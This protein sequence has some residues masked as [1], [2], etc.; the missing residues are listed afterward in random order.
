M[1]TISKLLL[2]SAVVLSSACKKKDKDKDDNIKDDNIT[3][4]EILPGTW[5]LVALNLEGGSTTSI[6][7]SI[8]ITIS[9]T[10]TT[11]NHVGTFHFSANGDYSRSNV[12]WEYK[13]ITVVNGTSETEIGNDSLKGI[14]GTWSIKP[15]GNLVLFDGS[16]EVLS[17]SKVELH[18]KTKITLTASN[19]YEKIDG[20][21]VTAG[22]TDMEITLE[23][24]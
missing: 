3:L 13:R 12:S 11:S 17:F 15:N 8:I 18:S 1:K 22:N 24:V 7:G 21:E 16:R 14:K 19:T 6:S 2:I 10:T 5:E 4:E 20:D 23:K 9:H